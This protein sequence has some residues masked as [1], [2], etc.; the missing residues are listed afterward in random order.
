MSRTFTLPFIF[1]L[2][3]FLFQ[4]C[5]GSEADTSA[6]KEDSA[7]G[8]SNAG[9]PASSTPSTSSV[10]KIEITDVGG[11]LVGTIDMSGSNPIV[12]TEAGEFR[13]K[14]K[15]EKRKYSDGNG[16]VYAIKYKTDG[17]KLRTEDGQLIWKIKHSQEK[18]K[19]SDN[20][21]NLNPY[22]I[23][24]K[25]EGRVKVKRNDEEVG[26]AR[27]RAAENKIEVSAG[28]LAYDLA[29]TEFHMGFGVLAIKE[30]DLTQRLIIVA[31]LID[32]GF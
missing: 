15:G 21:E 16:L 2:T 5:G 7:I 12:K 29:T 28:P 27:L 23:K 30:V 32:R 13:S 11:K 10:P 9:D 31:E 8:L 3:F 24:P 1:I 20:E 14:I 22:E 6:S 17:F 25:E 4:A 19:V 26:S 18:I